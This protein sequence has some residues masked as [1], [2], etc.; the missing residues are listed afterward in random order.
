MNELQ[1]DSEYLI[2]HGLP[3]SVS[4]VR[5]GP[6]TDDFLL[7]LFQAIFDRLGRA[8]THGQS[9]HVGA[10]LHQDP[11]SFGER[12]VRGEGGLVVS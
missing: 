4:A 8:A 7:E 9:S 6:K 10:L 1:Q 5:S 11:L 12:S 3:S 2:G